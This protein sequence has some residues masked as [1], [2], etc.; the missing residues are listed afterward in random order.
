MNIRLQKLIDSLPKTK[1][2][3]AAPEKPKPVRKKKIK[4][5]AK[6]NR[7]EWHALSRASFASETPISDFQLEDCAAMMLGAGVALREIAKDLPDSDRA[8]VYWI[9][10]RLRSVSRRMYEL[11]RERQRRDKRRQKK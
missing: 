5:R 11:A 2:R 9:G 1:R 3:R 10:T 7:P 8:D 6:R 4:A